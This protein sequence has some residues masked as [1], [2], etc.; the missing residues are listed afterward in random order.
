MNG[1]PVRDAVLGAGDQVVFDGQHRFVVEFPAVPSPSASP[2]SEPAEPAP[3]VPA[4]PSAGS[5]RR[6]P[7]LLLA[8]LLL[9]LALSALLWFGAR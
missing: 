7:W 4:V 9:G 1:M 3:D 5:A 6:L 8:A 2:G